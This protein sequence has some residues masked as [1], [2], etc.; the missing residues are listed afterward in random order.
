MGGIEQLTALVTGSEQGE[1]EGQRK[2][3]FY[4]TTGRTHGHPSG[5]FETYRETSA[6]GPHP[7]GKPVLHLCRRHPLPLGE[8]RLGEYQEVILS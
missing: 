7:R 8:D 6:R 5:K 1:G 2:R 3:T 4:K